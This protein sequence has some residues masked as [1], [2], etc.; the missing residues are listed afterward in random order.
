MT[1]SKKLVA[2]MTNPIDSVQVV[3]QF[4]TKKEG[5]PAENLIVKFENNEIEN[6]KDVKQGDTLDVSISHATAA[7]KN[8]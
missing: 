4:I 7:V 8:K 5:I 1:P 6:L 3:K 2:M